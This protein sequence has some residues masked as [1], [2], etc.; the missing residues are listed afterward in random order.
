MTQ[1]ARRRPRRLRPTPAPSPTPAASTRPQRLTDA[2][3]GL[4]AGVVAAVIAVG[5]VAWQVSAEDARSRDEFR[6]DQQQAAYADFLTNATTLQRAEKDFVF[7]FI[8]RASPE[9]LDE[10]KQAV[11]DAQTALTQSA[12]LVSI[13]GSTTASAIA[14]R[15][16]S[17][18]VSTTGLI[19]AAELT[20]VEAALLPDLGDR[21]ADL[22]TE[23]SNLQ[24]DF[25]LQARTD[26]ETQP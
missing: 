22:D 19:F 17:V 21:W 15:V 9:T 5:G 23:T 14:L 6:R 4:I 16:D 7:S 20:G 11:D 1:P 24:S 2:R 12:Y 18:H 10:Q 8:G 13:V 3:S 26:L 25:I